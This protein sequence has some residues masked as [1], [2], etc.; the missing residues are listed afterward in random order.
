MSEGGGSQIIGYKYFA[1]VHLIPCAG[2]V[3]SVL[4]IQV[5]ERIAWEGEARN[6]QDL[7]INKPD[8]FGGE[9]REGGVSGV[10]ALAFGRIDQTRDNYLAAKIGAALAE[11]EDAELWAPLFIPAGGTGL[12][13]DPLEPPNA[14]GA[15]A[16]AIP[17]FR[18]ALSLIFKSF[19]WSAMNPYF[20]KV[21][22][23]VKRILT[24]W[25]AEGV[26]HAGKAVI[27][28]DG[29]EHMNPA[30]IIYQVLTN[31]DWG[32]GYP[33][34]MLDDVSFRAAADTL[35]NEAFG[36][37]TV[38]GAQTTAKRF[39]QEVLDHINGALGVNYKTGEFVLRLMRDDYDRDA[40]IVL[41]ESNVISVNSFSR[42][43]WGET[44]NELT[45]SYTDAV[46]GQVKSITQQDLANIQ[47]QGAVVTESIERL[48]LPTA[49]LAA[50]VCTR[51][52]RVLAAPLATVELTVGRVAFDLGV[53]DCFKLAWDDFG[54]DSLL[55]RVV[56]VGKGSLTS[57]AMTI[58]AVEDV[59]GMPA[60][61][62]SGAQ[63]Q[64]WVQPSGKAR[65]IVS[66][67]V[68]EAP[69]LMIA[70]HLSQEEWGSLG[71]QVGFP[72][73]VALRPST[74]A[75]GY[76]IA[77]DI[78]EEG[79]YKET[80][81]SGFCPLALTTEDIGR[82][83][84]VI[85]FTG[86][87]LFGAEGK[88]ALLGAEWIQ[89]LSVD[90]EE[91]VCTA[92]RAVADSIPLEHA[93]GAKIWVVG[94][95]GAA[96]VRREWY[97]GE[98]PYVKLQAFT[99]QDFYPRDEILATQVE[100]KG[101]ANLPYPPADLTVAGA[102][103]P[104]VVS[105]GFNVAWANR[106]RVGQ[107]DALVGFLDGNI[108]PPEGS[109]VTVEL[110]T[111]GS[112]HVLF[113]E[114]VDAATRF[115]S[116]EKLE[117]DGEAR[118]LA[119]A[120]DEVGDS[121]YKHDFVLTY[122]GEPQGDPHWSNVVVLLHF[123]GNIV[124]ETGRPWAYED[125][126]NT[127]VTDDSPFAS[128]GSLHVSAPDNTM[129]GILTTQIPLLGNDPHTIEFFLKRD[130]NSPQLETTGGIITQAASAPCGEQGITLDSKTWNI[131]YQNG[132]QSCPWVDSGRL[133]YTP[134]PVTI[135]DEF[136]HVALCFDSGVRKL[137]VDGKLVDTGT[138]PR[139]WG[140]TR[141]AFRI[142]LMNNPR[143]STRVPMAAKVAEV[144]ITAGVARYDD[145]FIPPFEPFPN[146]GNLPV[147]IDPH[148]DDV[149]VLIRTSEHQVIRDVKRNLTFNT[150]SGWYF[151]NDM[152][153]KP[154]GNAQNLN[155]GTK[156]DFAA[157]EDFTIEYWLKT[158]NATATYDS[159]VATWNS[160]NRNAGGLLLTYYYVARSRSIKVYGMNQGDTEA[161]PPLSALIE[162]PF[163]AHLALTRENGVIRLF[164]N[165]VLT[166]TVNYSGVISST[167]NLHLGNPGSASASTTREYGGIKEL[168]VTKNVCRYNDNFTPPAGLLP[169][170]GA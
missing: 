97:A 56:S 13:P 25:G 36:L 8:L 104:D 61:S 89:V 130:V 27:T 20:K 129:A 148:W 86:M 66:Y 30:H 90:M 28:I 166:D 111:L 106:D 96:I 85:P 92:K 45:V 117:Y 115:V 41:N 136:V 150:P 79:E 68:F 122:D 145:D 39:I 62:Y 133:A 156:M 132:G 16:V 102:Y 5:G 54:I 110:Q 34:S 70:P 158:D 144:R 169:S 74:N 87:G 119:W 134:D 60:A 31:D 55:F 167:Q 40:L 78:E 109:Q 165:G 17:A 138:E 151:E 120:S 19:Y 53:G 160:A 94:A 124:D 1:G 29:I 116:I 140:D 98:A 159:M 37:S 44:V 14:G 170:R 108:A 163:T 161:F 81:T 105:G 7:H 46:D 43:A 139:G 142:G 21:A 50:R 59:F 63:V 164:L 15:Q 58:S 118:L 32:L 114:T 103:Y 18:G 23:R 3:D 107:A 128:G 149:L 49:A 9:K 153:I 95:D 12:P 6:S 47:S 2:E 83:D 152:L 154:R 26:W 73:A 65:E 127:T 75:I 33:R 52:L 126:K 121:Y 143:Y 76:R 71:A 157:N 91:K 88:L 147:E 99:G 4:E 141:Q 38:M 57:G 11:S 146:F 42:K 112:S 155:L 69:Y 22:V 93:S 24:G 80:W 67:D 82:M 125:T 100:L 72:A 10:C 135:L 137:F 168:R 113:S 84:T 35:Y 77:A 131:R 101:R 162:S 48:G 51:E 64:G 123:D